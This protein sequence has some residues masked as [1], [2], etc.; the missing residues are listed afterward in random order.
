MMGQ[1]AIALDFNIL[2][3]LSKLVR[4]TF[5]L[6]RGKIFVLVMDENHRKIQSDNYPKI[7][8]WI[9]QVIL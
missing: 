2:F 1:S 6:L 7:R 4:E 3:F 9:M 8:Y 5:L